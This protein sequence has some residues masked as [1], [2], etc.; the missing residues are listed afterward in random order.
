[1][2]PSGLAFVTMVAISG[3]MLGAGE[4]AHAG[5]TSVL[6]PSRPVPEL[7]AV[8]EIPALI[9]LPTPGSARKLYLP[10]I[11]REAK[12]RGLPVDVAD[13]VARVESGYDPGVVGGAGERGLMQVMPPTASMLGFKGSAAELAE[14]ATNIRYG[15]AYLADAWRLANGDLC[16]TLMKYRAGHNEERMSPLSVEYCRRARGHLAAIGSPLAAGALPSADFFPGGAMASVGGE[17]RL[18]RVRR[19][20]GRLRRVGPIRTASVSRRFW[21]GHMARIRAIEARLPWKRGGIMT[22]SDS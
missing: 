13:A 10:L 15:V 4:L 17:P 11:E 20:A 16:R 7:P 21:A 1:M 12:L 18:G 2:R 9:G 8:P 19:I 6:P 14:P 22:R 3:V 5:E